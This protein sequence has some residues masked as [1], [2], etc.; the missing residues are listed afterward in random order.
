MWANKEVLLNQI[1][2]SGAYSLFLATIAYPVYSCIACAGNITVWH[3]VYYH[4]YEIRATQQTK[5]KPV[6]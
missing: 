4:F 2:A 3:M 5:D 6:Y 1:K